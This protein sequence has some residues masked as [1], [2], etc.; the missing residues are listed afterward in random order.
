[1]REIWD[2]IRGARRLELFAAVV[3]IALIAAAWLNGGGMDRLRSEPDRTELERRLESI[4]EAVDGAG[5]VRAMVSQG[6][7]GGV[8]GAVVVS[9]GL[10]DV[11]TYLK[12]Q[13]AVQALLDID[14]SQIR[15]IG[16]KEMFGGDQ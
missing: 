15:I 5:R 9:D 16:P 4:L 13:S 2:R 1:M 6:E 11:S 3:L 14:A 10:S 12:I 8:V 7:D